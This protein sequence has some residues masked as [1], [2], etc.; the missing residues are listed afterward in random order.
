[1]EPKWLT[2]QRLLN[3]GHVRSCCWVIYFVW[4]GVDRGWKMLNMEWI[5][6]IACFVLGPVESY[7]VSSSVD[8]IVIFIIGPDFIRFSCKQRVVSQ[9]TC[10]NLLLI[11]A[12]ALI[13][14]I[15]VY[16]TFGLDKQISI[17]LLQNSLRLRLTA[18]L[19]FMNLLGLEYSTFFWVI[20]TFNI[21]QFQ[22]Q[23][24]VIYTFEFVRWFRLYITIYWHYFD[25]FLLLFSHLY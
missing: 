9:T 18:I 22:M 13:S 5:H 12:L 20:F 16:Q 23:L 4:L 21:L 8:R 1:M 24:L 14:K 7:H 11:W 6:K 19:I 3:V 25:L 17:K 15:L 2:V 10:L